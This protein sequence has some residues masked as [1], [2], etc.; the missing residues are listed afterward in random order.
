ML[1]KQPSTRALVVQA[2]SVSGLPSTLSISTI[3]SS[4]PLRRLLLRHI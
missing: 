1:K 3:P 2:L 4:L